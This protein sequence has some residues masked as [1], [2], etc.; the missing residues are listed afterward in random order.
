MTLYFE[1]QEIA[2]RFNFQNYINVEDNIYATL[3][4]AVQ[5]SDKINTGETICSILN[6]KIDL[7]ETDHIVKIRNTK[8]TVIKQ[9]FNSKSQNYYLNTKKNTYNGSSFGYNNSLS[10]QYNKK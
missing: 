10:I 5:R 6:N 3:Q 2:L 8:H 9:K 4:H 1:K 7:I